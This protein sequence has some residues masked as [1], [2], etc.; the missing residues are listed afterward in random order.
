MGLRS[1]FARMFT[2]QPARPADPPA[3]PAPPADELFE[4]MAAVEWDY[5]AR[6]RE[7]STKQR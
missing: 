3:P 2:R 4:R 5:Y 6:D 1:M 7:P